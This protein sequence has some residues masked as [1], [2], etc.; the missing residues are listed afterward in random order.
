MSSTEPESECQFFARFLS[1][2]RQRRALVSPLPVIVYRGQADASWDL[3]PKL[4]RLKIPNHIL[5]QTESSIINDFREQFALSSQTDLDIL[6]YA[7]HYAAPTRL[8]DWSQNPL[9]ALWFAIEDREKDELD[10]LV[11]QLDSTKALRQV[12][13]TLGMTLSHSED[14]QQGKPIHI[15]QCPSGIERSKSQ[16]SVFTITTF[17]DEQFLRPLNEI[18]GS[19]N[20]DSLRTFKVPFALKP[21]LRDLLSFLHLDAYSIF[22]DPDSFGRAIAARLNSKDWV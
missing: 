10:G 19:N 15:F 9:I 20:C 11:W 16:K 2:A 3:T 4:C 6:A 18:L 21:A 13:P 14:C 5:K 22:G 17:N 7:Q 8:L 12:C 1:W